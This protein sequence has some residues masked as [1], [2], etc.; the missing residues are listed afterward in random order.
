VSY[1][2]GGTLLRQIAVKDLSF[3][4]S[5]QIQVGVKRERADGVGRWTAGVELGIEKRF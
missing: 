1:D 5:T 2:L 4:R 3:L